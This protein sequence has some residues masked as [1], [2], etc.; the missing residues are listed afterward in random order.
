MLLDSSGPE[1]SFL[2][3]PVC[4]VKRLKK[5]GGKA[6][7]RKEIGDLSFSLL[8]FVVFPALELQ[9]FKPVPP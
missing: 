2:F 5:Q 1:D 3:R 9:E 4:A 8:I 7:C 6:G